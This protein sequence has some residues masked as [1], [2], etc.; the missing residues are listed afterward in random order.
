MDYHYYMFHKPSGCITALS[1]AS[2]KTIAD[3]LSGLDLNTLRPVG[4]LDKDT[5]G[6]LI[7]TDNGYF[8]QQMTHPDAGIEKEYYFWAMGEI[9]QEKTE[10][11][12][13]GVALPGMTYGITRPAKLTLLESGTLR[14][15]ACYV[16]GKN[17]EHILKNRPEHPV[18]SGHII[19]TEGR[20]HEVRRLLKSIG[21]C[22][23]YLKRIRMGCIRLDPD[24][25]PGEYREFS[26]PLL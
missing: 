18:F 22:C 23:I 9:N 7:L 13:H 16:T 12:A 15:A 2:E 6:L 8:L 1:D 17:R 19:V 24:L 20:K 3:Y 4:R 5:E 11:L 25:K 26:P 10:R 21:C 14:D